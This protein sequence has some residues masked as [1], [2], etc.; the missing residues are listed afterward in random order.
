LQGILRLAEEELDCEQALG[1]LFGAIGQQS[2]AGESP[3]ITRLAKLSMAE[4]IPESTSATE[5]TMT[6]AA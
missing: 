2:L 3:D 5:P 4:S 1:S 6:P